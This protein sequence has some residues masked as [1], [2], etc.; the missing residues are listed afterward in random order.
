MRRG[1]LLRSASAPGGKA[2]VECV[3]VLRQPAA[4]PMVTLPG[5]LVVTP[6]HPVRDD[7][8]AWRF[9]AD[10]ARPAPV[11][12]EGCGA[13][14]DFVLDAR[15]GGTLEVGGRS[16]VSLAHGLSGC[17]TLRHPFFGTGRA[18]ADLGRRRGWASGRVVFGGAMLRAAPTA[19][20][21]QGLVVGFGDELTDE[22]AEAHPAAAE[23]APTPAVGARPRAIAVGSR[24]KAAPN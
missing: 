16:C 2:R 5:G 14:Y 9:P 19:T 11:G 21:P 20:E 10:L 13:V 6:H 4:R 18:L 15:S 3:V 23:G 22:L 1:D 17:A 7:A 8:G 12:G 24:A